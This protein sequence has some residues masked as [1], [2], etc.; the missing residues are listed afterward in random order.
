MTKSLAQLKLDAANAGW[1]WPITHPNDERAMLD[2][3]YPDFAAAEHVRGF[4][5][6]CL[7]IPAPG[8]GVQP[9]VLLDWWYRD[10]L[11]PVFG[12]KQKDG[13]RRYDKAFVTT[14]KKSGKSTVLSGLPLYMILAQGIHEAEAYATAVDRDQATLIYRKTSEM[15]RQSPHLRSILKRVDSQKRIVHH[16]SASFFEAISSDADTAD[17][18]NPVLLICDELHEWK[19]RR[20]FTKLMYGDIVRAE[21][22]FL[23][24]TTAGD[25][26]ESIGFEEYEF[27]KALLDPNDPFYSQSHFACIRE[28]GDEHEWDNPDGWQQANPSIAE[29]LGNL[30]KLQSKCDEA[31]KTPRKIREFT[32]YICNRWVSVIED[33]WI[34]PDSWAAC[35]GMIGNHEGESVWLG[36]DL[37]AVL[38]VTALCAAWWAEEGVIDLAWWFWMPKE[39]IRDKEDRWGVPLRAWVSDSWMIQTPGKSVNYRNIRGLISGLTFDED[40]NATRVDGSGLRDKYRI[41]EIAYDPWNATQLV[42]DLE[43]HDGHACVE[44]RQGYIS[45]NTPCKEFERRIADCEL[46]HGNNPVAKWMISHCIVDQDPAG[47]IKPNKKKSKH[48]IDGIVAA[49]MAAGRAVAGAVHSY[50]GA[51]PRSVPA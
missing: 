29:G 26:D 41:E 32:R 5:L 30:V 48:K 1:P 39:G 23:M 42:E 22:L 7:C 14:G 20:F 36:L 3:C 2:G 38:D 27:A 46:R 8:G 44:H 40:G 35:G 13:R 49:V 45:M 11:A 6:D 15:V 16:G 12:W 21:P 17:G 33:P 4:Y 19:D 25:D 9:F 37:S 51:G 50:R 28:A 31:R 34:S 18:L 43:Q 47:N 24:I 10:V